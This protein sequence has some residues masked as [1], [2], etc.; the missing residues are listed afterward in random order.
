VKV[1][2]TG[3]GGFIGS[4]LTA[5]LPRAGHE[6]ARDV[7]QANAVVHLAGVAHR[8]ASPEEYRAV[9][10]ALAERVARSAAQHGVHFVF[11]STIKVHSDASIAPFTESSPMAPQD[12][13]AESKAR[14]E[15]LL[16]S[17]PGLRLTILRP[18]L[19]YGPGVKA[20]FLALMRLVCSGW[21]LP[22]A[23]IE[24][25]RSFIYV[26]NLVD[27][28]LR[29]LDSPGTF[30]VS[31]GPPVSTAHLCR[32]IGEALHRPAR[33]FAFPPALLPRRL[34]GSLE[35]DDSLIRRTLHWHP[36]FDRQAGLQAT[37]RWFAAR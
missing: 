6:L 10:V 22:L 19:V 31:D 21:P 28:I 11:L 25:R 7:A 3:A 18:P 30:L 8:R 37:A 17:V 26:G 4:V 29:C 12:A 5:A 1:H 24:N 36:P 9:N 35:A 13:Y 33:L 14:A 32:E 34:A 16:R 15:D 27:A 20:N 2:V 23:S